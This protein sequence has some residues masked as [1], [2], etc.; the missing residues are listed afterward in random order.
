MKSDSNLLSA[1]A[2]TGKTT[3]MVEF[4]GKCSKGVVDEFIGKIFNVN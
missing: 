3:L 2:K 4:I 1:R